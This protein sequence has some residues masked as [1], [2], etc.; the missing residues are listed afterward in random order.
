MK[1]QRQL[2]VFPVG[3][4]SWPQW[5]SISSVSCHISNTLAS[6]HFSCPFPQNR[7]HCPF[8]LQMLPRFPVSIT[9]EECTCG[10]PPPRPQQPA[11]LNHKTARSPEAGGRMGG[12]AADPPGQLGFAWKCRPW[13][14]GA[15]ATQP[16]GSRAASLPPLQCPR[17][18]R[19][20]SRWGWSSGPAFSALTRLPT[21]SLSEG[22]PWGS[23]TR[24]P[25]ITPSPGLLSHFPLLPLL[26]S[27]F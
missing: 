14:P 6:Y 25:E 16:R 23:Q 15:A 19:P 24:L 10:C 12:E 7:S 17:M 4:A 5:P 2:P 8:S 9:Q 21:P 13:E 1:T 11:P 22:V 18:V 20:V 27:V 3:L 26:L